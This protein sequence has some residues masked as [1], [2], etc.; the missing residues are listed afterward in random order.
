MGLD[1]KA[2]S[3]FRLFGYITLTCFCF[4]LLQSQYAFGQVDEGSI[5]GTV[6][7]ATGAVV[8]NA[9]VTLLNTDQGITQQTR[10]SNS[11]GYTFSP[12]RIG[13]YSLSVTAKG[14]AKTT[15]ENLTVNVAQTPA[16]QRS[17]QARR[18][19]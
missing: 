10:T 9:Q 18:R 16:G 12:V 5:T 4:L 19:D 3:W 15:Q 17:A 7:D 6:Q 13:H 8:A 1:R 11:G 14:F 2:S